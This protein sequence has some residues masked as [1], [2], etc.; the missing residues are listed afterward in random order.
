[1]SRNLILA[2]HCCFVIR[3]LSCV[4]SITSSKASSPYRARSSAFS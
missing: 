4:R 1:L 2:F 3:S